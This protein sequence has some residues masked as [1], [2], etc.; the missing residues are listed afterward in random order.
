MEDVR[1]R[2][3]VVVVAANSEKDSNTMG[4][5]PRQWR[6]DQRVSINATAVIVEAEEIPVEVE[7]EDAT[8]EGDVVVVVDRR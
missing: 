8:E 7:E 2:L 1:W 4:A 3:E 5:Q 6:S